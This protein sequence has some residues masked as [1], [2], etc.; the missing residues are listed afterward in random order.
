MS[1]PDGEFQ[2]LIERTCAFWRQAD[3]DGNLN[4]PIGGTGGGKTFDFTG[5]RFTA[6]TS[7]SMYVD[8][9]STPFSADFAD[10]THAMY[11]GEGQEE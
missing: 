2:H 11:S 10:A 4:F 3:L 6:S 5:I 9:E 7:P 8:P 1:R